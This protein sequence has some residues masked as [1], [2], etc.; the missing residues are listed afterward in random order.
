L[1]FWIA[2]IIFALDGKAPEWGTLVLFMITAVMLQATAEFANTIKEMK[3]DI[4][5]KS[6]AED[7]PSD[8][9]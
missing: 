5:M 3:K 1:P 2:S 4:A 8:P 9:K 6:N 7:H